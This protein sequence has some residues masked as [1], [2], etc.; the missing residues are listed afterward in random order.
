MLDRRRPGEA[1]E[2]GA[3]RELI[4]RGGLYA[5]MWAKQADM[6]AAGGAKPT[7]SQCKCCVEEMC[8]AHGEHQHHGKPPVVGSSAD[9]KK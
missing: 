9:R 6:A 5:S 3:H 4:A 1:V 7:V 2:R 8:C